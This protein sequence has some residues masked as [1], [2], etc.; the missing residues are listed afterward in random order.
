M[1]NLA[2]RIPSI[3]ALLFANIL[4]QAQNNTLHRMPEEVAIFAVRAHSIDPIVIVHY[5]SDQRFKTIPS[6]NPPLPDQ[7][8][9]A[10]F[11]KFETSF[12]RQGSR[13]SIFGGGEK[14]GTA[15]LI[16][17]DIQ[18]RDGGFVDLS[19]KVTY[20]GSRSPFLA[21]NTQS[22]IAGHASTRR[23]A[24]SAE[25]SVLR[26]LAIQWPADYGL[27]SQLLQSARFHNVVFTILRQDAGQAAERGRSSS[28]M[29]RR[30]P[31]IAAAFCIVSS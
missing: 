20:T 13:F 23:V 30:L 5:G 24:N 7:P 18:G 4:L 1:Y 2:M 25:S 22:E 27:S 15:T 28:L 12:Y 8:T 9:P 6:L 16:S 19:A 11:D 21:T 14:L 26:K 10:D 17:S 31:T 3:S 29:T